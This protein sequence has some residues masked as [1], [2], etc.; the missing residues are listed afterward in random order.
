MAPPPL[1]WGA[2]LLLLPLPM[3]LSP[4]PFP[5]PHSSPHPPSSSLFSA[6]GGVALTHLAVHRDTG[7]VFVGAVN[8]VFKL[9]PNL[10]LAQSHATG[11]VPDDPRCYP[12]PAVRPCTHPLRPADNV[13]K[14]LLLDYAGGT[15]GPGGPGRLLACGSVWQGVCRLLRLSDLALL[16]EPHRRKEHYLSGG[17]DSD[18]MAGVIL[19][20]PSSTGGS[21]LF[22]GTAV[23]GRSEYFPT[24]SSRRLVPEPSSPDMFSLVYQDEFV[25][26][27]VKVPSDTLS[28]HPAFDIYY[29]SAFVSGGFVY[30]LTLQLDPQQPSEGAPPGSGDP[31]PVAAAAGPSTAGGERFFSSRLVRLCAG[32]AEF[33]SYVEFPLGC[34]QAGVEYGLVQAARVA[35]AGRHLA[36]ALGLAEG[37]DVLFA[38]FAQ[39]QKNRAMPPRRSLL[40]LFT[41]DEVNA[42][43]RQRI[44]ACY[45]GEGRLSLP[46]LLNKELPCINTPIQITG[47]FCGLVLN[48]PLGGLQPIEGRPLLAERSEGLA[49]VAAY[50][51]RGHTVV[52]LGTRAGTLKKVRVDGPQDVHLYES[53]PIS[54]GEPLLRDASLSPD[55]RHLYLLSRSQVVR[56]PVETCE[57]YQSCETCLGS[58]D[59][60][61]AWCILHHRCG[62]ESACPRGGE[63]G[64]LALVLA[65]CVR[66]HIEPSNASVTAPAPLL[67]LTVENVPDLSPGIVCVFVGVGQSPAQLLL[68]GQVTCSAPAPHDLPPSP[69][70]HG[71]ARPLHL[72]LRSLETGQDFVGTEFIFYNCSRLLGCLA[73]VGSP[74]RCHWCKYRHICAPDP[75]HCSFAEGRVNTSEGCPELL[76]GAAVLIPAGVPRPISLRAKNLPQPQSGQRGYE[77]VVGLPGQSRSQR[78]PAVRF[79][80]S[81]LQC[82]NASY[83][84]EGD[85]VAEMP[86]EFSVV[87][88]G[89][90]AI[91]QPPDF[92]AVLYKCRAQ[93]GSCGLC[94]RSDPQLECGWC[95]AERRCGLRLHCPHPRLGIS[96]SGS[97]WVPAGRRGTRCAHPRLTQVEPLQG[98]K[99]GGTRVTL[100][101]ENLGLQPYEV[102]VRVAGVYCN[103]LPGLYVPA[104]RVVCE[105]EES[106]V[107]DPP[108][109]PV[110][111][112]VGDCS[113]EF[114]ARGPTP[115]AFVTPVLLSLRPTVGPVSGGTRLTVTGTHLDAGSNVS[116]ALRGAPCPLIRRGPKELVC[117]TP[118]SALG[119]GSATLG[120]CMD[121][122]ALGATRN[123][124]A[125]LSYRYL[126]DPSITAVDPLWSI[127]NGSTQLVVHGTRLDS[128]QEPRIRAV[129]RGIETLNQSCQVLN[130][131]VMLCQAPGLAVGSQGLPPGG[132]QPEEFGFVLDHVQAARSLNRSLFTYFP[133]PSIEPF[134]PSGVLEVQP[135]AHVVLKGK[136]LIPAAGAGARLNYRVLIGGEPC[137]LTVSET[138]L[139]CDSPH[140]TGEQPVMILV[141]GLSF[142]PGTL[143]IYPEA[144][145]PLGALVGLGAGG[146]LLL[147]A[148]IGVLVAYKR[149]TRDADRTLK[150]LQLQMD[151][152][153][154]RVAL[155]CKEAFAELQ[156]DIHELTNHLDGVKI[157][158]RGYR[159]YALRVL[160]P[161]AEE[162]PLLRDPYAVP[163]ASRG[164]RAFG[165]LLLVRPFLLAFV[166]TLEAQ[167]GFAMRDRGLVASLLLVALQ[168]RLDYATAVLRQLLADLIAK[169]LQHRAHPKL[170]LR[171]TESVAEKMLTNWFTFLLH[172]FLKE[173]AGEPLYLLFCA[174]K[175]QVEKGP[176]D[177]VTGEA[178]YSL[179]EDKLIRQQ[180]DYKTLTLLCACPDP[181]GGAALPVKVLNCDTVTQAKEKLLDALHRGAPMSQ[182]PRANDLELEWCQEGSGRIL[183]Q[184]E[185]STSRVEG[186]WKRI[187]TLAHYQVTDGSTVALVPHQASAVNLT[188]AGG[189]VSRS[190]SRYETLLRTSGSPDSL[191]LRAP[192]LTP[193]REAGT[194]LWHLVR[195]HDPLVGGGGDAGGGGPERGSKMVSEIYLTRLLATKGTLQKFVDDL[196]ETVL[197]TAHR[198]SALPLAIKFMFDFLD[199]QA[200]RHGITDPDVRHTW[201]SNCLPLRFWVNVIKNPQFVFDVHKTPIT[202]ACLS[203]VAQTFMDSCSTSAQRLGKDSPSTKLLYAKDLPAYRAWV[204]RYYRDIAKMTTISDQDMDA[205]LVEQSRL[206]AGEFNTLAALG[207]LFHYVERYREEILT[208]LERDAYCRRHKLGPRLEQAI[209]LV[210]SHS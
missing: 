6:P 116:V 138:Q 169:D 136:N 19:E 17:P 193:E 126:P 190:L 89:N 119:P 161:G 106:L 55:Q 15:G 153:E 191:R 7:E 21:T 123:H 142:L 129:Y 5:F 100:W 206:H 186:D 4:S 203:V 90:F 196:F 127:A 85:A 30:F 53:V 23:E 122:A 135:G 75:T 67:L 103:P 70:P 137:A 36:R 192:I 151:N 45:R 49:S 84:Y 69:A 68:G 35:K 118:P 22:V 52:F 2:A 80:S 158:F 87:W 139:L 25:S 11:P 160:F 112:C 44:Q 171:R 13:N 39:G 146:S 78:I 16:A 125:A 181:P 154:S 105:M 24:L 95:V 113:A 18:A 56:L 188:G 50:T 71:E 209:T 195:S 3:A 48:Q 92:Q 99:E 185:D 40:C 74:F 62:R 120:M 200:D 20:A 111:V 26:S 124:T 205:Y 164:L 204:E 10:T 101:G 91:D 64:R 57:R 93:R 102:A 1:L 114:R 144:M 28:L 149:K 199:D 66:L 173:S 51:H 170:L 59:P 134:G 187:N 163:G 9:A 60:H 174:I 182:R 107:P 156:T 14:L 198:G 143:H 61:C 140:Q 76:P 179:S 189:S 176:L 81:S 88:D 157:P 130:D 180:I 58:G 33:Y 77:C 175:Q 31:A 207:E 8:R 27:Q 128:I 117:L 42:R 37:E 201:K 145:L 86:L 133:D 166:H 104:E 162:P 29:V 98:P 197:S 83:W 47:N 178:R 168:G 141:G 63:P 12:P 72:W 152:L 65:Q 165:Q 97:G 210:H 94:L 148:I 34:S 38:A 208:A 202:D 155:E 121:R 183:L 159:D 108:P 172:R 150:R 73:C 43:I 147:L 194:R 79:N 184:D 167:R 32:D 131:S 54:P 110:E 82:Q 177:A 109:G 132:V 115:F 46:W 41:L 96:S